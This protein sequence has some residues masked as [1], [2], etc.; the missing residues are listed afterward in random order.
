MGRMKWPI[1]PV[2]R[3]TFWL[4]SW[5]HAGGRQ[6][7]VDGNESCQTYWTK[8]K[9]SPG[10]ETEKSQLGQRHLSLEPAGLLTLGLKGLLSTAGR[11]GV[12]ANTCC[13]CFIFRIDH[14][15]KEDKDRCTWTTHAFLHF[16]LHTKVHNDLARQ[17][18]L[19]LG[20][21]LN[22]AEHVIL[23]ICPQ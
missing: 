19:I 10:V 17:C 2:P 1:Q 23:G 5:S 6:R 11:T 20:R 13:L 8:G 9:I 15:E 16:P 3:W 21:S 7:V 12:C 22:P 14:S 18:T 4:L